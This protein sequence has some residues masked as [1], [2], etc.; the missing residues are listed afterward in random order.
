[1]SFIS[2][3]LIF[4]EKFY[5]TRKAC[6]KERRKKQKHLE[7][8]YVYSWWKEKTKLKYFILDLRYKTTNDV[9]YA[10]QG[11]FGNDHIRFCAEMRVLELGSILYKKGSFFSG[12]RHFRNTA[13]SLKNSSSCLYF[14]NMEKICVFSTLKFKL[15]FQSK[16][17]L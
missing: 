15:F 4:S 2:E 8:V 9:F 7:D 11:M 14:C 10:K 13:N 16:L 17:A 6:L 3:V 5:Y 1:M 12:K